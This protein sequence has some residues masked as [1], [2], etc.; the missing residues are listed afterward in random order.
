MSG[1]TQKSSKIKIENIP[2]NMNLAIT[3]DVGKGQFGAGMGIHQQTCSGVLGE[4]FVKR[5]CT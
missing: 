3:G 1:T 4:W 2:L 5:E